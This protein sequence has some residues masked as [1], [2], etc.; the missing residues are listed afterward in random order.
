MTKNNVKNKY[1]LFG[2][3]TIIGLAVEAN[4]N[5]DTYRCFFIL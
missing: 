1:N 2:G 3:Y 5:S 4:N